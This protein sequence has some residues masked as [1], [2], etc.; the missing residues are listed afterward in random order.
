MQKLNP[1]TSCC[2][3]P[4]PLC[5]CWQILLSHKLTVPHPHCK[6]Q[7]T[8]CCHVLSI[9]ALQ[10]RYIS[11]IIAWLCKTDFS[12]TLPNCCE[13]NFSKFSAEKMAYF[14]DL[15]SRELDSLE[16]NFTILMEKGFFVVF[17]KNRILGH[18]VFTTVERKSGHQL[19]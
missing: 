14:T 15:K 5:H 18:M 19:K 11:P 17:F 2:Y 4:F 9:C 12:Q 6:I 10:S 13:I 3:F 8:S 16:F 7:M 1:T